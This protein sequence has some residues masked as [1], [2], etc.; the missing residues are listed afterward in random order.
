MCVF[1]MYRCISVC[2]I[3]N[4]IYDNAIIYYKTLQY[5]YS[6]IYYESF[7]YV[8]FPSNL[9]SNNN[10]RCGPIGVLNALV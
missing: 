6:Y 5:Y 9:L 2:A 10:Q 3:I 1:C 4:T 8:A 7:L